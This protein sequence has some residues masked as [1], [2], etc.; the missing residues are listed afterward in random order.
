MILKTRQGQNQKMNL[1]KKMKNRSR[2]ADEQEMTE[3]REKIAKELK[4]EF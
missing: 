2:S 4:K 1:M 3:I